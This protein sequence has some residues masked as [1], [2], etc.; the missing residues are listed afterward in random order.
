MLT[1]GTDASGRSG[2]SRALLDAVVAISTDLDLHRV[3]SR[4]V[5]SACELTQ[6]KY[7]ALGVLDRSEGLHD[8]IVHGVDPALRDQ[9]GDLPH[10]RGILGQVI[11]DPRPLRLDDLAQHASSYGFPPHHPPMKTFLGVPIA[12]HG[13]VFGNLYLTEKAG[14]ASFSEEDQEAVV[15]LAAAAGYVI[16]NARA[17]GLSERRR[18]WLEAT[19]RVADALQPPIS[20]GRAFAEVTRILRSATGARAT[21]VVRVTEDGTAVGAADGPETEVLE[22]LARRESSWLTDDHTDPTMSVMVDGAERWAVRLTMR[23]ALSEADVI[24]V[25]LDSDERLRDPQEHQL[26]QSFGEHVGLAL[27]R[28]SAVEDRAA[29]AIL[30]DRDRIA[31]DLHDLV[32]QRLFATGM[33][34]Q[35]L[36]MLAERREFVD[37]LD[38]AVDNIDRTIKDIRGTIFELQNRKDASLRADVRKLAKEYSPTLGFLATVRTSGPVDTAVPEAVQVAILAVVREALSNI[39]KHA[40]AGEAD[41]EVAVDEQGVR[42][43]VSDDGVGLPDDRQES[44]LRNAR[45]RAEALGGTMSLTANEPRGTVLTWL[46]P[47]G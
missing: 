36:Q 17:Y 43:R 22:E 14:G 41:V 40:R 26:M 20:S 19:G 3:L 2:A 16:G 38:K 23:S 42:V 7:G 46:A 1:E 4:I 35:G 6:A 28:A 24:V 18:R 25:L 13:T 29:L 10:G 15:A 21:A 12:V 11:R 32:I 39:A 31:R 44:G 37:G 30:S 34:L 27:D 8:F 45:A 5:E 9:I 33:H 47:V